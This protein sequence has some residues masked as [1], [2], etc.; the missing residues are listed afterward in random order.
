MTL[1][2]NRYVQPQSVKEA[3]DVIQ[4]L[5]NQYRHA[6]LT[7]Q[8]LNY[9]LGLTQ[10]L[11]SDIYVAALKENN[12]VELEKLNTMIAAMK[13]WTKIRTANRPFNGKMKNYQLVSTS[14]P[15]FKQHSHKIKGQ[16]NFHASRH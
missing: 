13:T 6:P 7:N 11:Q 3:M 5:F 16:H 14:H 12:S 15:K 9:H 1:P 10:R 4:D 2:K 8:L